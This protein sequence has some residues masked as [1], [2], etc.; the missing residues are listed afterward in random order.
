M[1]DET[2][3]QIEA[4]VSELCAGYGWWSCDPITFYGGALKLAGQGSHLMGDVKIAFEPDAD[5]IAEAK[6]AGL[7]DGTLETVVDILCHV[8]QKYGV[9]WQF[10]D[11]YDS[12]SFG[13]ISNG[14][15]SSQLSDLLAGFDSLYAGLKEF[16]E[17]ETN[18][19]S[20]RNSTLHKD[21]RK[22]KSDND[23]DDGPHILKFPGS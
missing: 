6:S 12:P 19:A 16:R 15:S 8:S 10:G 5:A 22:Q 13:T 1:D 23:Q 2:R 14:K 3:N 4:E 7:P 17:S 9:D 18:S 20:P 11:D 21:D